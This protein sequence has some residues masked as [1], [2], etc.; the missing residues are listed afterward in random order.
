MKEFT[1][2][3]YR[4]AT[5][6]YKAKAQQGR[7]KK[8]NNKKYPQGCYILD[9]GPAKSGRKK[10]PLLLALHDASYKV[11]KD[12]GWWITACKP[13]TGEFSYRWF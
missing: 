13:F 10:Y 7:M 8:L 2:L 4:R 12:A 6:N 9:L 3:I 11:E 5:K 1:R